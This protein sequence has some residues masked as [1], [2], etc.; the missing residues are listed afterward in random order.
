MY[1][2]HLIPGLQL[3]KELCNINSQIFLKI[4]TIT[5]KRLNCTFQDRERL[6]IFYI[7]IHIYFQH[8]DKLTEIH[9]SRSFVNANTIVCKQ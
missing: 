4:Y 5:T 9:F 7:I 6:F 1:P 8:N 3:T 2:F